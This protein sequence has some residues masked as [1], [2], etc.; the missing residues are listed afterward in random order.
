ML[1]LKKILE[2]VCLA[3]YNNRV[4]NKNLNTKDQVV[5]QT[6]RRGRWF[7]CIFAVLGGILVVGVMLT[8]WG[9]WWLYGWMNGEITDF[10]ES[11]TPEE[12]A[13]LVQLDEHMRRDFSYNLADEA[14]SRVERLI[15]DIVLAAVVR[16]SMVQL[17]D[18]ATSGRA[19]KV[20]N[21]AIPAL[22]AKLLSFDLQT[23]IG[24]LAAQAAELSALRALVAHGLDANT[25]MLM[26]QD[27]VPSEMSEVLLSPVLNNSFTNGRKLPWSE[28]VE[29]ANFLVA[30]GARLNGVPIIPVSCKM[31]LLLESDAQPFLW[32]IEQGLRPDDSDALFMV[33]SP[34][35]L[36]VLALVLEK[37]LVD[38]NTYTEGETLLQSLVDATQALRWY[39]ADEMPAEIRSRQFEEKMALL[40]SAGANPDLVPDTAR[41]VR[42]PGE[43]ENDYEHR[44]YKAKERQ[45]TPLSMLESALQDARADS[46]ATELLRRLREQLLAAGATPVAPE[47]CPGEEA[48]E[49]NGP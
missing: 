49:E 44:V 38:V 37:K 7:R 41:M 17:E 10:H 16:P 8:G 47:S 2:S 32:A 13:A 21:T 20:E 28:R 39:D 9:A 27:G 26:I 45:E 35:G 11:W 23:N 6:G 24:V 19:D 31:P 30:H 46:P 15:Q 18:I 5:A 14:E 25:R 36:P 42:K 40:L 48:G 3:C 43:D 22:V 4:M 34:G 29:T 12:R 33:A 1:H